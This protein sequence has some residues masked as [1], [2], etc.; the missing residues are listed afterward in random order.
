MYSFAQRHDTSVLDEPFYAVYLDRSKADHPGAA[1]VLSSLS[2]HEETVIE[3]IFRGW[4]KPVLFIKN[5]A[6]HIEVI[7]K[8]FLSKTTNIFLIRNPKQIIASYAEVIGK[9][10]MRDIG[11]EYEYRLF[12]DLRK[13]G[14]VPVVLDSGV[15]LANPREVLTKLCAAIG[16][17]FT[18]SMLNWEAGPKPYDGVWAPYWY[19]NVHRS[20][21]FE[22]QNSSSRQLPSHLTM[23][24]EKAA[25]YYEKL[26]SFAI[27]I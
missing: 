5:M 26:L 10:V 27:G 21:G 23:L 14:H 9:P 25:P 8:S 12:E 7:D 16:L 22:K 1:E 20:T 4:P 2:I 17:E 6:H 15:L 13:Q 24:Y 11:I 19:G 18:P 3:Q